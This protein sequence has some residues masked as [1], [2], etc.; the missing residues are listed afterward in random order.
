MTTQL[1]Y[2]SFHV[3]GF[4]KKGQ[5]ESGTIDDEIPVG[6]LVVVDKGDQLYGVLGTVIPGRPDVA[7]HHLVNSD[8][9]VPTITELGNSEKEHS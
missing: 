3:S 8:V 1:V 2:R 4:D 6:D 7:E 9:M 5:I